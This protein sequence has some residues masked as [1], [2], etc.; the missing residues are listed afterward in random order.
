MR[1]YLPAAVCVL[2]AL[3]SL[4]GVATEVV[5]DSSGA[6]T[7]AEPGSGAIYIAA[8]S[9]LEYS[10]V[11]SPLPAHRLGE[12]ALSGARSLRTPGV[13]IPSVLGDMPAPEPSATGAADPSAA[14]PLAP[15]GWP[16]QPQMTSSGR[17]PLAAADSRGRCK[18]ATELARADNQRIAVLYAARRFTV[19]GELANLRMLRLRVRYRDGLIAYINGTEVARRN[20]AADAGPLDIAA[21]PHGPEW[22]TFY[23]PLV[24]GLV[25]AGD[26]TLA[27]EVRPSGNRLDPRLDVELSSSEQVQIVRGPMVQRVTATSAAIV[28]ETDL[29]VMGAVEYGPTAERGRTARSAG[30]GLATRHVVELAGLPAGK[31]VYY[32][33]TAGSASTGDLAFHTAVGRDDV[34]RFVVYGD[35]RGGH[36]THAQIVRSILDEAPDFTVVTGDLVLRGTD[37]GDWQRFFAVTGD[38]LARIPYYPAVGNHDM[39]RSG[40]QRRRFNEI[41]ELWPGPENRPSWG[42][43][44]S[45]EVAG[46]HFAMIDSNSYQHSEQLEW[47]DRDL[48]A[49]RAR[50]VRAIFAVV[51]D[52]PYS[53][54]LHRGNQFAADNYVPVL[55][56]HGA[57]L[58]FS[59]H[60]HLYQRGRVDG[61]SY[62][63]SG[64]GGAPL[65][66]VRCGI[67]GKRRCK[68]RDGMQF[69]ASEHHYI[70]VTVYRNHVRACPKRVDGSP[71]EECTNY[72]LRSRRR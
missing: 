60:D 59:G 66:S 38:L 54:G 70:V 6:A 11:L 35:V 40:D 57:V 65:Y 64:G 48:A 20:L 16:A 58:T 37:E 17:A 30:G 8:G 41:F 34:V 53:R 39:G 12:I 3:S 25:V 14:N 4:S 19:G 31:K 23:V 45:F 69:V 2:L 61:F 29:P 71:L 1:S 10:A 44:Y 33:V 47:L 32:R 15:P 50:G 26:N 46:V 9:E 24:P 28:F 68:A 21:R 43:W 56:R 36:D 5:A 27:V 22:E 67:P 42:H 55:L 63:V 7:G 13:V 51:H 18:C 72:R 49:A 52:G 62:M